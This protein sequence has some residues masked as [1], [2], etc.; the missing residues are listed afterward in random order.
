MVGGL[1]RLLDAPNHPSRTPAVLQH[2]F[3]CARR[4]HKL[5][6]QGAATV[7][8]PGPQYELI[9]K[10]A[11]G[12]PIVKPGLHYETTGNDDHAR[13]ASSEG[14]EDNL[15]APCTITYEPVPAV[16]AQYEEIPIKPLTGEYD[17]TPAGPVTPG[18]ELKPDELAAQYSSVGLP[19]GAD[20][21]ANPTYGAGPNGELVG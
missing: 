2:V 20:P 13:A 6:R 15:L 5:D 16:A 10:S 1:A 17:T 8:D 9:D 18:R 3:A 14:R 7:G 19:T 21:V 4:Y 11:Y 12:G